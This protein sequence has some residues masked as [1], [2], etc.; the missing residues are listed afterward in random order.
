MSSIGATAA[1]ASSTPDQYQQAIEIGEIAAN[2]ISRAPEAS[3]A[4]YRN[5]KQHG[6][7]SSSGERKNIAKR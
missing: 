3:R 2:S 1:N 7:A 6:V 5:S 4:S